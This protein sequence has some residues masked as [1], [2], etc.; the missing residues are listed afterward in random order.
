MPRA[1]KVV[2]APKRRGR[3]PKKQAPRTTELP[4]DALV[5]TYEQ[6]PAEIQAIELAL[7][8]LRRI[9][10]TL[11]LACTGMDTDQHDAVIMASQLVD[12]AHEAIAEA[13][14]MVREQ[15]RA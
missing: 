10:A 2:E 13:V 1:K 14:A 4:Q 15:L 6:D 3:P 12:G 5:F 9:A 8:R 11:R 7:V